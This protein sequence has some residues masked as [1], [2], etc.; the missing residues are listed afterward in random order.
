[1]EEVNWTQEKMLEVTISEP[2]DLKIVNDNI[3]I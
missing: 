1:M 3:K 2:D